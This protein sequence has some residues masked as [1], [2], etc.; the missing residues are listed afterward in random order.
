MGA[1][2]EN[3]EEGEWQRG[4]VAHPLS[5]SQWNRGHFSMKKCESDKH[6]NWGMPAEGFKSQVAADGSL[7]GTAGKYG[8]RDWTVVQLD[9]DEELGPLHG[10]YGSMEAEFQVHRTI[11]RAGLTAFLCLLKTVIGPIKVH[12]D[13]RGIIDVLWR[14]ER[15][16]S[17]PNAGDADL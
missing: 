16:C 13:N 6:K 3:F 12:V 17:K 11:K 14:G 4:I 1:K 2:N 9:Y 15:K 7:L 10:M 8:A 5:D